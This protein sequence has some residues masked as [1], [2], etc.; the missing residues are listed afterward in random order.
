VSCEWALNYHGL[1]LQSP[2]ICTI[3]T[4]SGSVGGRNRVAYRGITIEYSRISES[5]F[6]GF[7]KVN[8]FNMATPEKALMDTIYL[9]KHVPFFDELETSILD[10]EE[11]TK[12][13]KRYPLS[14][15]RTMEHL[16]QESLGEKT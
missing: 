13:V 3:I 12:I 16:L 14:S 15:Q 4:L 7:K 8:G 1:I 10:V 11:L 5:L 2:L 9:R 6:W